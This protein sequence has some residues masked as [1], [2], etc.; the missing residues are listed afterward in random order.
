VTLL[1][2]MAPAQHQGWLLLF[3]LETMKV[4]WVL[5]GGQLTTLLAAEHG[6]GLPRP[7]LDADVLIDVRA[8]P[9]SIQR[10]SAWLLGQGLSFG[11]A[12]PELVGHRFSRPA[13]PGPGTVSVD[14]LAPEGLSESTDTTTVPP[15]RTVQVP[16]S[17]ALLASAKS[18][19][20]TVRDLFGS[21]VAGRVNRPSV[22]AALIGKAAATSLAVRPDRERDWQ[23]AA[24]LA[25]ILP[26]P[27]IDPKNLSKRERA[28]LRRLVRS[29]M[30]TI[31]HG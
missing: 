10:V 21:S 20:V 18:V 14:L 29:P 23:D 4:P 1:D 7:T 31:L 2:G 30:S 17:G 16:A 28:H 8:A 9:G 25:A 6:V 15:A 12:S 24:L 13:N 27:R 11:G 5:V 3:G 19:D 22:L 26:D